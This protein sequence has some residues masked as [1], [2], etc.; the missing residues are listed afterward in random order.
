MPAYLA[1]FIGT[2][3]LILLGN[4]VV[5]NVLLRDTKGNDAG[6]IVICAGWGFAVF[7]AVLCVGQFSGAHL[8]PAVTVGLATAGTFEWELVAGYVAAQ[9]TGGVTGAVLVYVFYKPHYDLTK[10]ENAKLATF[11]TAPNIRTLPYN[12]VSELIATF[13]LVY[14]VLLMVDP[15]FTIEFSGAKAEVPVGLGSI[16]ALP[17]GLIVFAIGLSLGGTTGYAINP[18]RDLG[19]RIAH[20]ILPIKGKRDSDWGY[21]AIP[22]L[23]PLAG[24]VL[25]ALLFQSHSLTG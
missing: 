17:V 11:C 2:A 3:I 25:A 14:A 23:G 13:V 18:A 12:F 7:T 15:A 4:G 6:W 1:E 10:D 5:A 21:A 16:G 20:W 24:G 22:V 19:P 8:N 9:M